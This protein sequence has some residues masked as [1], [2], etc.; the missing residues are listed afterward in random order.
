[1][2]DKYYQYRLVV[3]TKHRT[4]RIYPNITYLTPNKVLIRWL[5]LHRNMY[6]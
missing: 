3:S 5:T 4:H 2:S 6:L 1:M